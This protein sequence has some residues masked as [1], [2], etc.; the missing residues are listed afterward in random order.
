MARKFQDV[1]PDELPYLQPHKE[2]NFSIEVYLGTDP[3]SIASY[4]MTP[5][6]LKELKTQLEELLSKGFIP[7][8]TSPWGAPVLFVKKK[9][10]MLRNS[11]GPF[12]GGNYAGMTKEYENAFQE[13]NW[14]L[15]TAP[16]LT[17]PISKEL[18]TIYYDASI[19]GL[20]CMLIQQGK[21]WRHY[22]YG[23]K[24]EVYF[25][26]KSLKYIFTQKDLNSRKVNVVADALSRKSYGQLSSLWLREFEM[27][28]VIEDFELC[29]GWKG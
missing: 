29:L 12:Q 20:G 18:F 21:T 25:D 19:V 3:I 27:H 6:E 26:Y 1:F 15:T 10:G 11:S 9:D 16:V 17:T 4:R 22:L 7:P 13:L 2:F 23:E 8:S 5:L 24:F 14:K 28:T